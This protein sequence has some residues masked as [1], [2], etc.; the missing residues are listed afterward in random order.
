MGEPILM[1]ARNGM[2]YRALIDLDHGTVDRRI[3]FADDN[4]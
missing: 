4:Y 3:F 2:D 1:H